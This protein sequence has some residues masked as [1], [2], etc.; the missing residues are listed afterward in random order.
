MKLMLSNGI[1]S[2]LLVINAK[3]KEVLSDALILFPMQDKQALEIMQN[4]V[5]SGNAPI[6]ITQAYNRY[7]RAWDNIEGGE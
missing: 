4:Y 6:D 2:E 1:G 7:E 5:K 3:T